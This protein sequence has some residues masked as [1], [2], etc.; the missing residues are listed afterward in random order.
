M[1]LIQINQNVL[2]AYN[3]E[4]ISG[5]IPENEHRHYHNMYVSLLTI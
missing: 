1:A 2:T 4:L 3:R 5:Y